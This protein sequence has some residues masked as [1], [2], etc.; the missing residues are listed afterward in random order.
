[1]TRS[2]TIVDAL[3]AHH[4]IFCRFHIY[5]WDTVGE[6]C[7]KH[8][9]FSWNDSNTE[10]LEN[11][12]PYQHLRLS[13]SYTQWHEKYL[14]NTQPQKRHFQ[15]VMHPANALLWHALRAIVTPSCC[16]DSSRNRKRSF[17]FHSARKAQAEHGLGSRTT[18]NM[19]LQR[20]KVAKVR[21]EPSGFRKE[22]MKTRIN[23]GIAS[24]RN[25]MQT[26]ARISVRWVSPDF[27]FCPSSAKNEH[28]VQSDFV[29]TNHKITI[30]LS[31]A[32][33]WNNYQLRRLVQVLFL[34][35][36]WAPC[37]CDAGLWSE[38][39]WERRWWQTGELLPT[40]ES[41]P[42]QLWPENKIKTTFK[43]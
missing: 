27:L 31:F 4:T 22:K 38:W 10:E 34:W 12:Q 11:A 25:A 18:S 42:S 13:I 32:W 21:G 36:S 14:E 5:L 17:R 41:E 6:I 30:N 28:S 37:V 40:T 29:L 19:L 15:K 20:E 24:T 3:Q 1:M 16:F 35:S 39:S 33:W 9:H 43:S 8:F 7:L 26:K 2:Y 23:S